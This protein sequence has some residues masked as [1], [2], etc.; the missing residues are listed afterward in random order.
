MQRMILDSDVECSIDKS[1]PVTSVVKHEA[2]S[3]SFT[4]AEWK[5]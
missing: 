3:R 1:R 4:D 5:A 2:S